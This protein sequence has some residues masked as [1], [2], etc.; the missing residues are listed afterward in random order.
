MK[1]IAGKLVKVMAECGYVQKNGT[2]DFH[3]YRY[4]MASDVLEK[5]HASLVKNRVAVVADSTVESIMEGV[6]QKGNPERL[7]T[8]K[9]T[10]TLVDADSGET[11]I[12]SGLGSG[13]DS[14][15]KAVMKAQTAAVKY[16]W[17]LTLAMAT[18]DDPEAD[19]G[20][21]ERMMGAEP[22]KQQRMP[23][24]PAACADCGATLTPGV[25]KVSTMRYK[26]PLCMNCQDRINR[27]SA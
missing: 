19:V 10:L 9:T 8:V 24:A 23:E 15:D 13:Q 2:N 1:Q 18:G 25:L 22:L 12:C 11:M 20:V 4:A 26:K 27:K 17:M 6:N 14:G 16:A 3:R 7:A 5:V 21:D